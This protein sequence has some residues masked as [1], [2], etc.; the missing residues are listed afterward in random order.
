MAVWY[1]Q[2]ALS[3]EWYPVGDA[4]RTQTPNIATRMRSRVKTWFSRQAAII[5]RKIP[6]ILPS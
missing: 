4:E 3:E 5:P 2:L 6:I 1:L